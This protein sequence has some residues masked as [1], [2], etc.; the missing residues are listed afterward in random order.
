MKKYFLVVISMLLFFLSTSQAVGVSPTDPISSKIEQLKAKIG[1]LQTQKN[2]LSNKITQFNSQIELKTLQVNTIQSNVEKLTSEIDELGGEITRLETEL[3]KYS[4]LVIHRIPEAYKRMTRSSIET[5]MLSD[6]ISTLIRKAKYVQKMQEKD[7][8]S[9]FSLK[10]T[11]NNFI[12]RKDTRE[13]KKLMQEEMKKQ[14]IIEERALEQQKKEKQA[15]LDQTKNSET[16]YQKQLSQALA[17]Q[18]AIDAAII[19]GAKEGVVKKGDPIALVGN[20]GYPGCST[21]A[22]LHFEVR[23]NNQWINAEEYISG[24]D[25]TDDQSGGKSRIG[26]GSWDWPLDGDVVVTQRYGKT[27]YSWRYSYSGGIHT[28]IDMISNTTQVIR[29]PKDGTLYSSSQ[30]CGGSSTI[31]IKYID[32]GDGIMSFYLHVQ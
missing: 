27:P 16:E 4:E 1:E 19:T 24:R 26:S 10:K 2:S 18:R 7:A 29:A 6:N 22:H 11:Q 25:V 30:S 13:K 9:L 23:K 31:K 32:H 20:T 14:L 28:G 5:L 3:T 21:G 8:E 15:L 12:E 17:E